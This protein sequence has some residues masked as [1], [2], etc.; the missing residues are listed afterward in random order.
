MRPHLE[1]SVQFWARHC[2]GDTDLLVQQRAKKM[3]KGLEILSCEE[4]LRELGL[5]SMEKLLESSFAE[6]D[7]GSWWTAS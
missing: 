2:E 1:Y 3:I 6:K 5:I 7:M 4:R